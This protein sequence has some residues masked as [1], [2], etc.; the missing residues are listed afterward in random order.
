MSAHLIDHRWNLN[1][2]A[3]V[4]FGEIAFATAL[5]LAAAEGSLAGCAASLTEEQE[6]DCRRLFLTL[7]RQPAGLNR[8]MEENG[9]AAAK[10]QDG[11]RGPGLYTVFRS[12]WNHLIV[13][14][15]RSAI[16]ARVLAFHLLMERTWGGAIDG[17]TTALE[18]EE[19]LVELHPAVVHAIG[20]VALLPNRALR[21]VEFREQIFRCH[22]YHNEREPAFLGPAL[23]TF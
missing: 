16:C 4:S 3:K 9:Q 22:H 14:Q 11:A 13:H 15:Q 1:P 6:E 8:E 21:E 20:Q 7:V 18:G 2:F 10:Q 5:F 17:W 23:P 12:L 19:E